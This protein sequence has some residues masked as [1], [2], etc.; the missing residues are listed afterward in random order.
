[1]LEQD[2]L[3]THQKDNQD[4]REKPL[5]LGEGEALLWLQQRRYTGTHFHQGQ[6]RAAGATGANSSPSK[7]SSEK[8]QTIELRC[9]IILQNIKTFIK[10]I[11]G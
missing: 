3:Q 6:Q 10:A 4:F 1:M 9:V 8:E 7:Y 2:E 5:P 11:P